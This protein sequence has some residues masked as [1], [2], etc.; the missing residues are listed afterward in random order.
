MFIAISSQYN[1]IDS[2]KNMFVGFYNYAH[3]FDFTN[4]VS[5]KFWKS[6]ATMFLFDIV[7]VPTLI[8]IPLTLAYLINLHPPGY[9]FYRAII[10]LPSVNKHHRRNYL[11]DNGIFHG[12]QHVRLTV[13]TQISYKVYMVGTSFKSDYDLQTNPSG[14]FPSAGQWTLAHYKSFLSADSDTKIFE[15]IAHKKHIEYA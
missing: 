10:Y 15:K 2:S 4:S 7:M 14:L 13:Q 8:I 3:L 9:K 11:L 12:V 5:L 6:F 1:P